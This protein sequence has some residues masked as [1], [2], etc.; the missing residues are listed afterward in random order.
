MASPQH[1]AW[2]TPLTKGDAATRRAAIWTAIFRNGKLLKPWWKQ[3]CGRGWHL[4]LYQAL[5][6]TGFALPPGSHWRDVLEQCLL[7]LRCGWLPLQ[8]WVQYLLL[9]NLLIDWLIMWWME[10]FTFPDNLASLTNLITVTRNRNLSILLWIYDK[11]NRTIIILCTICNLCCFLQ[12][13]LLSFFCFISD[14]PWSFTMYV[15]PLLS[16]SF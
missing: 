6:S 8:D 14:S 2:Q 1:T 4:W 15:F 5:Q 13:A 10:W 9:S 7:V 16:L 3:Q 12:L 11:L